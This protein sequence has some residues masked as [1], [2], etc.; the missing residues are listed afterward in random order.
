MAVETSPRDLEIAAKPAII[1]SRPYNMQRRQNNGPDGR[2]VPAPSR[3]K[4]RIGRCWRSCLGDVRPRQDSP[5]W[6]EGLSAARLFRSALAKLDAHRMAREGGRLAFSVN[7]HRP[8]QHRGVRAGLHGAAWARGLSRGGRG[9]LIRGL[10]RRRT[11]RSAIG[12][13]ADSAGAARSGVCS[14]HGRPNAPFLAPGVGCDVGWRSGVGLSLCRRGRCV[15][16]RRQR[17]GRRLGR[18]S[19]NG[20][21]GLGPFSDYVAVGRAGLRRLA[22]PGPPCGQESGDQNACQHGHGRPA[23]D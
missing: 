4:A 20:R 6:R 9:G 11:P 13:Q 2:R 12:R 3:H 23:P 10:R 18:C 16:L 19:W 14:L 1:Q 7:A 15:L 22:A 17:G 21:R 5:L 8:R